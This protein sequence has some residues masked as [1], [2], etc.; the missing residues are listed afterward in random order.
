MRRRC[1]SAGRRSFGST[2]PPRSTASSPLRSSCPPT[3]SESP[4]DKDITLDDLPQPSGKGEVQ[5]H[6]T[7]IVEKGATLGKG[8]VVGPFCVV[9]AKVQL[10]DWVRLD[11]HVT[12]SGR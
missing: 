7:A 1:S 9:G 6:P 8:V 11:S 10:H 2:R 12:V 3:L 5:I 4:V